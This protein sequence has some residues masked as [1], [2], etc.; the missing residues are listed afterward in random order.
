MDRNKESH[1]DSWL[2][3]MVLHCLRS[4]TRCSFITVDNKC[5]L[6]DNYTIV[7][8]NHIYVLDNYT[9]VVDSHT[10]LADNNHIIILLLITI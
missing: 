8:D 3:A 5:A 9:T 10:T 7:A 1:A 2:S 4:M 6:V